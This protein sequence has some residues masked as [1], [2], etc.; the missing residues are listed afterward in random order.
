[1]THNITDKSP[2]ERPLITFALIAYNQERYIREAVDGAFAQTYSPLEIILSDDCSTDQTFEIMQEMAKKYTGPHTVQ[3]NKNNENLG[4][5]GHLNK[6]G[7]MARGEWIGVAA[8]DDISLE[9][10]ISTL[11]TCAARD[12]SI[13]AV[14][15][16]VTP[17]DEFGTPI[18]TEWDHT[19]A[20]HPSTVRECV[21]RDFCGVYGCSA[22]YKTTLF[23]D[24]GAIHDNIYHEDHVLPFRALFHGRIHF[25]RCQLVDYRF[26]T[27]NIFNSTGGEKSLERFQKKVLNELTVR[28]QWI[29]DAKRSGLAKP[30]LLW[31]LYR[32]MIQHRAKYHAA[33]G[34]LFRAAAWSLFSLV[35]TGKASG[36]KTF[37]HYRSLLS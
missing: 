12:Q 9:D 23:T 8:G 36:I 32:N 7:S 33:N 16:A 20:I 10:R 35:L 6:I 21:R 2:Q 29:A 28:E 3:L 26:H 4:I 5:T 15:S 30:L 14:Y 17:V 34:S 11:Y 1:M 18:P 31:V 13:Q 27:T 37:L 19:Q 25:S 24:F 22:F